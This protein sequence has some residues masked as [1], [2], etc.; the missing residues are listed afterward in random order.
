MSAN[1][2]EDIL[3]PG[4]CFKIIDIKPWRII[5]NEANLAKQINKFNSL[6]DFS[7]SEYGKW[8]LDGKDSHLYKIPTYQ[9]P[10]NIS[11]FL[12]S[13][14][15]QILCLIV[16]DSYI[17]NDIIIVKCLIEEQVKILKTRLSTY[18]IK[19]INNSIEVI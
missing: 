10:S 3:K 8:Y 11:N 2:I 15:I 18:G 17:D 1:K 13:N 5:G 12:F 6:N 7:V 14:N 16:L 4:S 19:T 9:I